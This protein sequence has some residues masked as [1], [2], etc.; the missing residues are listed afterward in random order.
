MPKSNY[1][2]GTKLLSLKDINGKTPEVFMCTSNRSAGKTTY[3]NRLVVNRF[4]KRGEKFALLYRFNY[5]LDGCDEKFFKDIKE[6]FFPEY[7][8]TAAKKMKGIYQELYLNEESCGYAISINSADQLKRNSHLFSD[9]DNIIFDEFQSEQNHYCDKEVE[10][11]ISIHNSIAR[12]RSKQ[13][14]Y[15]PVYM[16]SNPVTILNPYYVAMDISTRLQKDTHFLRGDGFVLEQGYNETAAKALKSSAFNRAFGSSDYIA[17]SA[18]GVYLQDD[19]SFVD[20]P[21]GRGKYVATIRY[22]GIDYG[23]REYPELGIVFC[24]KSVDYQ[25]P[26]K[27][28]V[29]T[30]DHKLNYVM[31]SSNF[32]LIQKLRY[33]FEHGCMRFKDLQAKE[34]I[35]KA[36][37]F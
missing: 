24:D 20:T 16:I 36:L 3:F 32:I 4:I 21:T 11:F 19:L 14:R 34:A 22:A 31:V 35:L 15:V 5:E 33:Y 1:Y 28:T 17:Y 2:D 18:E 23:V 6:L 26:L 27:I 10:K 30:A 8:M 29:D 12:G 37:S 9:I 25:Y 7:D 13:S